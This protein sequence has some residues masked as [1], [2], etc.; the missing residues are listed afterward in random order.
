MTSEGSESTSGVLLLERQIDD[1]LLENPELV[2]FRNGFQVYCMSKYSL[3]TSAN[4]IYTSGKDDL[5]VAFYSSRD[6]TYHVVQC[7]VPERDWLE[8]N[9]GKVKSFGSAVLNDTRVLLQYLQENASVTANDHLQEL[10]TLVTADREQEEFE[11]VIFFV[12]YGELNDRGLAAFSQLKHEFEHKRVRLILQQITDLADEYLVGTT[13][14]SGEI[15]LDL[16]YATDI[17]ILRAHDYCYFLVNAADLFDGFQSYGWRLFDLNLRYEV[18]NS[19]ING[20][21]LRSLQHQRTRRHFHHY[22]NGLIVVSKNYNI[23]EKQHSIHLTGPQIVNGLQTV[24]SIYNAVKANDVTREQLDRECLVQV[25]VINT[26][27][28]GFVAKVVQATNN[29]N[30][31]LSRNLKANGREQRVL[32]SGFASLTPRWFLQVKEGEWESLTDEG[33]RF[34]KQ[35]VGSAAADFKPDPHR[36]KGR[37]VDNQDAAKAWLALMGFADLA[38]DRVTHYF[39]D[40]DVYQLAFTMSPTESHWN[41]FAE[42][43]DFDADRRQGLKTTQG[44]AAQYMV[45]YALW[46]FVRSFVPSAKRYRDAALDAGVRAG[47]LEKRSGSVTSLLSVQEQFLADDLTYQTWRL[48]ANM[49]ELLVEVAA[50]ILTRRYGALEPARCETLLQLQEMK[51]FLVS[52]EMPESSTNAAAG[53]ELSNDSVLARIFCLLRYVASQYWEDKRTTLLSTSRIRT[54]LLRREVAAEFKTRVWEVDGRRGLDRAWKPEGMT[55]LESLP[56]LPCASK[57]C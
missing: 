31:M 29:Q 41:R 15:Q 56:D 37:V 47:K 34:F 48:M 10:R 52:D 51:Y 44:E 13:H 39:S 53:G 11:L 54:V 42:S 40:P 18:R 23:R 55:F 17:G 45:A 7:R 36:R 22:N 30:P 1:I 49:K 6:R 28:A 20:D 38:G 19:S 4:T 46:Q 27:D 16:R 2:D 25:K 43:V 57:A 3:G 12:V 32:R 33:G 24:K 26:S 8:A 5:G 50:H 9:Q 14:Q 21:I 35:I